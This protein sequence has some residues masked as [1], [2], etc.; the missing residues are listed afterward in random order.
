MAASCNASRTVAG[1]I[2]GCGSHPGPSSGGALRRVC[3]G[4]QLASSGIPGYGNGCRHGL[5]GTVSTGDDHSHPDGHC[6]DYAE[7]EQLASGHTL[8]LT[9]PVAIIQLTL[10]YAGPIITRSAWLSQQH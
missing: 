5:P 2:T 10:T 8:T 7:R 4:Q 9:K 3:P 1:S 6:D